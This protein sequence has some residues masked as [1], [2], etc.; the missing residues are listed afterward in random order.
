[1]GFS[2]EWEYD[3]L[4]DENEMGIRPMGMGIRTWEWGKI[5]RLRPIF[6]H[7]FHM[8]QFYIAIL[9]G[10]HSFGLTFNFLKYFCRQ[11]A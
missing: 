8:L 2:W 10:Y 7:K 1:M 11:F 3:Q 6:V 5:K 4:W 9:L